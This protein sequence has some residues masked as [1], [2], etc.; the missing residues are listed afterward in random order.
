MERKPKT[1]QQNQHAPNGADAPPIAVDDAVMA[2]AAEASADP[3]PQSSH[4]VFCDD[5][6]EVMKGFAIALRAMG[7]R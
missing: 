3:C 6:Q 1:S 7:L 5:E 2:P 4:A